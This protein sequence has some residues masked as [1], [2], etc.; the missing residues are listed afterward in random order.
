MTP[1]T[2]KTIIRH[3]KGIVAALEKEGCAASNDIPDSLI[4][5]VEYINKSLDGTWNDASRH[6]MYMR[7]PGNL[8]IDL[9]NKIANQRDIKVEIKDDR[10]IFSKN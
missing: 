4:A 1:D 10:V 3:L 8:T 2:N 5:L 6:I 7:N 9:I